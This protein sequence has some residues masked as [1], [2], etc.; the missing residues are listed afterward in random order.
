MNLELLNFDQYIKDY[1]LKEVTSTKIYS[2]QR[3]QLDPN[4]LFSEYIFGRV[5]SNQRKTTYGYINLKTKIIHPE[6]YQILVSTDTDLTKYIIGKERY[7]II[8]GKLIQSEDGSSGIYNF[9]KNFDKINFDKLNT[10]KV[11]SIRW[12]KSNNM[13]ISNILVLPAGVR[14]I[15]QN[16]ASGKVIV[17][18]SDISDIYKYL[19][20]QVNNI[21]NIDDDILME[22]ITKSLQKTVL[23]INTWIKSR[24]KGKKGLLR[25]SL[26]SKR[27]DFSGRL[28][29]TPDSKMPLGF[30]GLPFNSVLKLFEPFFAHH[31]LKKRS[32]IIPQIKNYMKLDERDNIDMNILH[33]FVSRLNE[34]PE[35]VKGQFYNDLLNIASEIVKDKMVIYKRDPVE[36][37]DSWISAYVQV[38][39]GGY[40]L[41]NNPLDLDKNGGDYDG[42]AV[43]VFSLLTKQAQEQAK[44]F[45]NPLYSKG[46]WQGVNSYNKLNYSINLDSI[47]GI[48]MMTKV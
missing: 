48:Y 34:A 29:I 32:D 33:K 27:V 5:G 15:Q 9:I 47:L 16:T 31:I 36:S 4:G 38:N 45:M 8:D 18:S 35:S 37:R 40:T 1:K 21:Y 39:P 7:N 10:D 19:I 6:A 25:G 12:I 28:N 11:E 22:S 17:Q 30:V 24:L 46:A 14:D 26:L 3:G 41:K 23:E 13:F 44:K 20:I 42:D 2:N 43:S